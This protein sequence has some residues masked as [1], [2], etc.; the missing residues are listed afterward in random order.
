MTSNAQH[1]LLDRI[2]A[3]LEKFSLIKQGIIEFD[4][5]TNNE[6]RTIYSKVDKSTTASRKKQKKIMFHIP[7]TRMMRIVDKN[8]AT[9]FHLSHKSISRVT[10]ETYQ[11][12]TRVSP[13]AA[14]N[15]CSYIERDAAVARLMPLENKPNGID[16]KLSP[17]ENSYKFNNMSEPL[18]DRDAHI[19]KAYGNTTMQDSYIIR[20]T[21]IS[22]Q[23]NGNRA[24]ITNIDDDDSAR[25]NYWSLVEE[26]EAKPS[27]DKMSLKIS[28]NRD[29][30]LSI[31]KDEKCPLY[32]KNIILNSDHD[33]EE[34]FDIESVEHMRNYLATKQ[35]CILPPH[36]S[37]TNNDEIPMVKFYKG[38]GG[39]IQFRL[40]GELPNELSPSEM[41][42]LLGDIT[43]EFSERKLPFVA[44][45]HEPDHLNNVR[46][47]HFHLIYHDRPCRRITKDDIDTLAKEGYGTANL[48]PGQWDF[49]AITT[50]RNRSNGRAVPLKQKKLREV[51]EKQ[52][53]ENLRS[54]CAEI[55]NMHLERAGHK[56][57]VD[58]RSNLR[59]GI[60]VQPT[61]HLG[62]AL[63]AAE[64]HGEATLIGISNENHQ[65]NGILAQAKA[66]LNHK[67]S[68]LEK[69]YDHALKDKNQHDIA[70]ERE[71]RDC[72]KQAAKFE[73]EAFVIQQCILRAK[74]RAVILKRRNQRILDAYENGVKSISKKQYQI[75]EDIVTEASE[76]LLRLT[77]FLKNEVGLAKDCMDAAKL[78]IQEANILKNNQY[79]NNVKLVP[80]PENGLVAS[81]NGAIKA[82]EVEHKAALGHNNHISPESFNQSNNIN[83]HYNS[84]SQDQ[85]DYEI[86]I[87][88]AK[89]NIYLNQL[90]KVKLDLEKDENGVIWPYDRDA[91]DIN[92]VDFTLA[93]EAQR[94]QLL[95]F[96]EK[97]Q[98]EIKGLREA[99]YDSF[100][101]E[102]YKAGY[103][104]IQAL[105]TSIRNMATDRLSRKL[106][107]DLLKQ[108]RLDVQEEAKRLFSQCRTT[109][110]N[111]LEKKELAIK[112]LKIIRRSGL[113]YSDNDLKRL[114]DRAYPIRSNISID[115][116]HNG[117]SF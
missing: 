64:A 17:S 108:I 89:M 40:T 74:S 30:W 65:W 70:K 10:Y 18:N 50:K 73:Y 2:A 84:V 112:A 46:N 44:V 67:L 61:K 48:K 55:M 37:K 99:L 113:K 60:N 102:N 71:I 52:W 106:G 51:A 117:M 42:T 56:R 76:Y 53:I 63:A 36:N 98:E 3:A 86:S 94:K 85:R 100:T 20:D 103:K 54:K 6:T 101:E 66:G 29:F 39:R 26:H 34:K 19:N 21:A 87:Q 38:R 28:D 9:S 80:L 31:S 110:G 69:Q 96:Y 1:E 47:W 68:H 105:P 90:G 91:Q 43:K 97:Q 8:G 59:R 92:K 4:G 23:P 27:P 16:D 79:Q 116:G 115:N 57:R 111:S 13:G 7:S 41:F 24:L 82:N 104:I 35:G 22:D 72:K 95:I 77:E 15:H 88:R 62:S 114:K 49:T 83:K 5:N 81:D 58:H 12:G 78:L 107:Q 32:L 33:R 93:T 11:E 14:K 45:M 25:A 109:E 75:A